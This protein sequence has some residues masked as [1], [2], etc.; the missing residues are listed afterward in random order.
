[1]ANITIGGDGWPKVSLESAQGSIDME[2]GATVDGVD[3]SA[4]ATDIDAHMPYITQSILIGQYDFG[5]PY[6]SEGTLALTADTIYFIAFFIPR[7]RT[8][9]RIGVELT[10]NGAAGILVRLGIYNAT[11]AHIPGALVLDAGTVVVDNGAAVLKTI[12]ISKQLIP[13]NY[14]MAVVSDG[15]PTLRACRIGNLTFL[16]HPGTTFTVNTINGGYSK[17]SVGSAALADPAVTGLTLTATY[18]TPTVVL[19]VLT[20]D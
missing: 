6:V 2:A 4:H 12:T 10:T 18:L 13:G 17:A 16:G 5:M 3:I 15:T 20:N 7:T 8:Y 19:R 11:S 14:F 9:D 1:M